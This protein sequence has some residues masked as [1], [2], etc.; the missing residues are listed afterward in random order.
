MAYALQ[1]LAT[2]AGGV[3][4]AR[5]L[6]AR[7][8]SFKRAPIAGVGLAAA[9]AAGA[10]FWEH[11]YQIGSGLPD[12]TQVDF[13]LSSFEAQHAADRGANN[14]FLAWARKAMLTTA[15]H[16]RGTYYLEPATIFNEP[17]LS[18]WSTYEL[19]PERATAKISE[20]D[21]IVFYGQRPVLSAEQR[22]QFG[23]IVEFSPGYGL[24]ARS[25]AR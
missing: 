10:L 15:P 5:V 9:L 2:L 13:A 18:Q 12:A 11:V 6:A 22:H 20:A 21:W 17:E 7:S 25:H 14:A 23:G 3:L 24:A 19:L 16:G 4:L 1:V 8:P